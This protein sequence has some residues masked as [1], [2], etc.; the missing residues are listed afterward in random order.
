MRKLLVRKLGDDD[1]QKCSSN[2]VL[3]HCSKPKMLK[4]AIEINS[5]EMHVKILEHFFVRQFPNLTTHGK[6]INLNGAA[7]IHKI[8]NSRN[9][10]LLKDRIP[11]AEVDSPHVLWT[12]QSAFL[13]CT[14]A[15]GQTRARA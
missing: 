8:K 3:I 15:G 7:S 9:R 1:L 2:A 11:F 5:L 10:S 6:R 13:A 12:A 4:H 14:S